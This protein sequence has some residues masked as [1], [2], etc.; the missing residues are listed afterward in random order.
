MI[1]GVAGD[2][3]PIGTTKGPGESAGDFTIVTPD[4]E[5]VVKIGEFIYYWDEVD[6]GRRRIFGRVASRAH[7]KLYPDAFMADPATSPG[8]VARILGFESADSEL[9]EVNV[10]IMGHFSGTMGFVNP[11]IAP[12][13]GLPVFLAEPETLAPILSSKNPGETGAVHVGSLLTRGDGE[14]PVSMDADEF[15]NTHLA[16]IA[17]TGAG[18]SYLAGVIVEELLRPNNAAAVLIIDPHQEYDTLGQIPNIDTFR[19]S[20][21]QIDYRPEVKIFREGEFVVRRNVMH[22]DD[23]M[24]LLGDIPTPQ[25]VIARRALRS[26]RNKRNWIFKDLLSAIERVDVARLSGGQSDSDSQE[27]Y[28]SSKQAL[29]LRLQDTLGRRGAFDDYKH[30]DMQE[31]LRPGRCSVLQVGG[32]D[33]RSQ[34]IV[35]ATILRRAFEGRQQTKRGETDPRDE[36]HLPFPIFVL[37]EEAH[38]FAPPGG[39]AATSNLLAE[40]LA[41]GRK[42]GMGIGLITQRPGKLDQDV[43]SQCMTQCIMRIVNPV[44]QNAVASAVESMGRDLLAEL[45][46]L[47]KGQAIVSGAAVNTTVLCRVR[48]RKTPHGGASYKS[49]ETWTDYFRPE[50]VRRR[51]TDEAL[52]PQSDG[53]AEVDLA[54]ELF[55]DD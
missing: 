50:K 15:A 17:G 2:N 37:I 3:L 16:I 21:S 51:K 47:S 14:V 25:R 44:D 36:L 41:E 26:L 40:I 23:I 32:M 34:Q 6:G 19:Q 10:S 22:Q 29:T 12:R 9:Y 46:A 52:F 24:Y 31:L 28:R 45:P 49:A 5:G 7:L 4:R 1:S 33:R 43:L 55:G 11:R 48:E 54:R 53:S 27:D 42:F 8:E 39:G 30:T 35:V 20:D 13:P 18:K 38:R